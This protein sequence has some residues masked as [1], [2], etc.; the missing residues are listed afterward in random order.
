MSTKKKGLV[1]ERETKE[2][3]KKRNTSKAHE[4]LGSSPEL[5]YQK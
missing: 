1:R 5:A 4:L 3:G 2:T